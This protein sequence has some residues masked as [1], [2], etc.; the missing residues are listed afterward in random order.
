[1]KKLETLANSNVTIVRTMPNIGAM[2][3]R[4]IT[5]YCVNK[6]FTQ[7]ETEIINSFLTS[8]TNSIAESY[9]KNELPYLSSHL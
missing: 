4:S 3:G 5:S 6:D 9:L 1:M 2:L 7:K 8:F